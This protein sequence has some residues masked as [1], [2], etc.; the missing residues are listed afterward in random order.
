MYLRNLATSE[1]RKMEFET[2]F[3]T[4]FDGATVS[5][6]EQTQRSAEIHVEIGKYHLLVCKVP[7]GHA[8]THTHTGE[9]NLVNAIHSEN[10]EWK[11]QSSRCAAIHLPFVSSICRSGFHNK[12]ELFVKNMCSSQHSPLNQLLGVFVGVHLLVNRRWMRHSMG[13]RSLVC[14]TRHWTRLSPPMMS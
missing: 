3:D 11:T 10:V 14:Y 5:S 7:I 9:R 1:H 4:I 6:S 2:K 12:I 8:H 13:N